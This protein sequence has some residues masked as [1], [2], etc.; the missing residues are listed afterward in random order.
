MKIR[1]IGFVLALIVAS[2]M[3]CEEKTTPSKAWGSFQCDQCTA[4]YQLNGVTIGQSGEDKYGWCKRTQNG[5]EFAV[6]DDRPGSSLGGGYYF[7]IRGIAGSPTVGVYES[8]QTPKDNDANETTFSSARIMKGG[9]DWKLQGDDI[10]SDT[11][12]VNLFAEALEEDLEAG[13]AAELT[14]KNYGSE[15]FRYFV[16][17]RCNGLEVTDN[18]YALT[19]MQITGWFE[20]CDEE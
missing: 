16:E 12:K 17:I 11:C 15:A 18:D 1:I 19:G 2:T 13:T 9:N 7:E 10:P 4:P 6:G 8:G 14:P 20:H 5:F 3:S